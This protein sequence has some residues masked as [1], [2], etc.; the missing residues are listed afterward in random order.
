MS[1]SFPPHCLPAFVTR[2]ARS[3]QKMLGGSSL[4]AGLTLQ[5]G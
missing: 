5:L 4:E 2:R 3:F 1:F